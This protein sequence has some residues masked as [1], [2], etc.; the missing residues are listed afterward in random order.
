[1]AGVVTATVLLGAVGWGSAPCALGDFG[2]FDFLVVPPLPVLPPVPGGPLLLT[3][4]R[5]AAACGR[6]PAPGTSFGS[7]PTWRR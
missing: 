3:R 6:S 1:M 4:R 7:C 5:A 2:D